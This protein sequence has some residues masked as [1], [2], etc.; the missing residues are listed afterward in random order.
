MDNVKV[1]NKK[2]IITLNPLFYPIEKVKKAILDFKKVGEIIIKQ[3][4]DIKISITPESDEID[5][6]EIGFQFC[7]YILSLMQTEV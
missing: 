7:D 4:S 3:D 2:A 6:N 5:I 1:E